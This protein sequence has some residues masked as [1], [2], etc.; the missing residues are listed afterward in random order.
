MSTK[1]DVPLVLVADDEVATT[2]MLA[3]IFEREGYDVQSVNDGSAALEAARRLIPDLILLDV[4]MPLM[5]GFEV[6]R[7]LRENTL[8]AGIPTII[9]TAKARQPTD[10]AHGLNLGA[11]DFIRKP[12]EPKEL[13]ARAENK[14]RA[15]RLEE[16]LQ[17]KTQELAALLRAGGELNQY[18]E[19]KDVLSL[20]TYL[21]LDLLPGDA[22]VIYQIDEQGKLVDFHAESKRD[23][24]LDVDH[25]AVL[26]QFQQEWHSLLWND[27]NSSLVHGFTSGLVIP[28]RHGNT[29][30]G[31]LMLLGQ[32]EYDENHV[33]LLEGIGSQA[34]L[35]LRNAQ[36]YEIQANYAAHLEEM[37]EAKTSELRSAHQM[38]IRAEKLA[39]LGHLAASI[40]HEINN[41]LQPIRSILDGML[42]D[43]QNNLSIDTRDVQV[44][45]ESVERIR[46]IVS[47]LLEFAGKRSS[48]NDPVKL[49][50]VG[51]VLDG[52]IA[53][54]RKFFEKENIRIEA[55]IQ[56]LELIYGSKDHL[57]QVFMNLVLNAKAAM[58]P[59][60]TLRIRAHMEQTEA[61]LEFEDDGGG[62]P[63]EYINKVFDP[64]FSTKPNGTGLGLFVS[65]G[66]IQS[67]HG[68]IEVNSVV[69]KG[70]RFT[71]RLPV[72]IAETR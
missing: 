29:L 26:K 6:L 55:D 35:T 72:H 53:L 68:T 64:F 41:P 62:I 70:T 17:R 34:A 2:I 8:T 40:A 19:I 39:S 24:Q 18:L 42:E 50:D 36:L 46:R 20:V 12:F 69:N 25:A 9:I 38:L 37:V 23:L 52:I 31:L 44:A 11:D 56:P 28:L 5:T 4:Q 49:L 16:A 59:G 10:V 61:V 30:L 14:I 66:I 60:G 47:Q 21:V 13:I 63:D 1:R 65:Y 7:H 54:N 3:R 67:H 15:R 43:L 27:E 33:R 22:A 48:D 32:N 58:K 71:I 57:E 45:Q 51:K